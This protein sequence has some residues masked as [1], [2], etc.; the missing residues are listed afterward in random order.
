MT[1]KL[2][3]VTIARDDDQ[4]EAFPDVC[5]L[6][7]DGLL[8]IYRESDFHGAS[9]SR[10]MLI[11]SDDRG[12]TWTNQ[13]QFDVSRS[14]R[15]DRSMWNNP[16]LARLPD[17]RIVATLDVHFFENAGIRGIGSLFCHQ[18][19]LSFSE[20]DGKTWTERQLTE[21]EGIG[22][23]RVVALT[24]RPLADGQPTLLGTVS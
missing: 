13:R 15:E 22:P 16:R 6:Q 7:D 14:V 20:D 23:S 10:I 11:E 3:H 2:Q 8:C 17:G 19:W 4:Y 1:P 9:T 18:T 21:V 12:R 24:V 5:R